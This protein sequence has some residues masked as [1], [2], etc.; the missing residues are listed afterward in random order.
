MALCNNP[1]KMKACDVLVELSKIYFEISNTFLEMTC[2]PMC[3][4]E[5]AMEQS[6]IKKRL[7]NLKRG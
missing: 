7:G 3:K 2:S 1:Y 4:K 5:H 6:K